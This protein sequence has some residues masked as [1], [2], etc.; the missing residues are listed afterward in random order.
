[1]LQNYSTDIKEYDNQNFGFQFS[2][3]HLLGVLFSW[4][5]PLYA[6][7]FGFRIIFENPTLVCGNY[8]IKIVPIFWRV[9]ANVNSS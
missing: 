8:F 9:L 2:Y 3:E 7:P 1:M 6:L 5:L 4:P